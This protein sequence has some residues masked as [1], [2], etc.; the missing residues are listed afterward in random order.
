MER[1]PEEIELLEGQPADTP[2]TEEMLEEMFRDYLNTLPKDSDEYLWY[3]QT[4][5]Q[6]N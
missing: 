1:T 5:I 4:G 2:M 3:V 6:S